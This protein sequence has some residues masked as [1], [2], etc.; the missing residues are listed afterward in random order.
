[1]QLKEPVDDADTLALLCAP[2]E[3]W[4]KQRM[5][6]TPADP[7]R[8]NVP[9]LVVQLAGAVPTP[10]EMANVAHSL[11]SPITSPTAAD[12]AAELREPKYWGRATAARSPMMA[13]TIISSTKVKPF[14]ALGFELL[15]SRKRLRSWS[16]N[17]VLREF[18]CG[19]WMWIVVDSWLKPD[20]LQ[21]P[22]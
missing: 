5:P 9:P 21:L 22:Q 16:L 15:S 19:Y 12:K 8:A 18:I 2:V 11:P 6:A 14:A 13:T 7:E 20:S 4:F 10:P 1:V 3:V 17:F